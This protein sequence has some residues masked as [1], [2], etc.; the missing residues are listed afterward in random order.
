[1]HA[2]TVVPFGPVG[3]TYTVRVWK[4]RRTPLSSDAWSQ[5]AEILRSASRAPQDITPSSELAND[6]GLDSVTLMDL[7]I[8]Y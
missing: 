7:V 3:L 6:L 1:M 4:R 5:L 2:R 8:V